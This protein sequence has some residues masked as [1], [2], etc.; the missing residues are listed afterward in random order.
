MRRVH[1]V[2][3]VNDSSE[4]SSVPPSTPDQ[5]SRDSNQYASLHMQTRPTVAV[6]PFPASSKLTV[7]ISRLQSLEHTLTGRELC[8]LNAAVPT[9]EI[10]QPVKDPVIK[11]SHALTE[12]EVLQKNLMKSRLDVVSVTKLSRSATASRNATSA[13]HN[14]SVITSRLPVYS[15]S[16]QLLKPMSK[17][18][19]NAASLRC[20]LNPVSS[21][22]ASP[23]FIQLREQSEFIEPKALDSIRSH[24]SMQVPSSSVDFGITHSDL[25]TPASFDKFGLKFIPPGCELVLQVYS[26]V[27]SI[28]DEQEQLK[29]SYQRGL[30]VA[31]PKHMLHYCPVPHRYF[32]VYNLKLCDSTSSI[33]KPKTST[34]TEFEQIED[35]IY[36][37][38]V[39]EC[40]AIFK[41]LSKRFTHFIT[42]EQFRSELKAFVMVR[43]LNLFGK[44][45]LVKSLQLWKR[46][47]RSQVFSRHFE[48]LELSLRWHS[49]SITSCV[50]AAHACIFNVHEKL[51][52][53][54]LWNVD[55]NR[56]VPQNDLPDNELQYCDTQVMAFISCCK[57]WFHDMVE[58]IASH[59]KSCSQEYLSARD[60]PQTQF[61]LTSTLSMVR[62]MRHEDLIK[63]LLPFVKVCSYMIESAKM[64][65]CISTLQKFSFN[66]ASNVD[67]GGQTSLFN[68]RFVPDNELH[69]DSQSY[70]M[71]PSN[72]SV[73]QWFRTRH[74]E[75]INCFLE[76]T[77]LTSREDILN[78]FIK[79]TEENRQARRSWLLSSD[80]VS[81]EFRQRMN[82]QCLDNLNSTLSIISKG[83]NSFECMKL[84][85]IETPLE[86]RAFLASLN[87]A[88]IR[89]MLMSLF[90]ESKRTFSDTRLPSFI[91]LIKR[92]LSC[93]NVIHCCFVESSLTSI[94]WCTLNMVI[95]LRELDEFA[96]S[97]ISDFESCVSSCFDSALFSSEEHLAQL[98]KELSSRDI[99]PA[100]FSVITSSLASASDRLSKI[101]ESLDRLQIIFS[102]VR[103]SGMNTPFDLA[104]IL[105]HQKIQVEEIHI[106]I[107]TCGE[108][109]GNNLKSA[110]KLLNDEQ[111]YIISAV[112][113][114]R[115]SLASSNACKSVPTGIRS[116]FENLMASLDFCHGI[117]AALVVRGN[118]L[119]S[120]RNAI[121]SDSKV[122][123]RPDLQI[124]RLISD[125]KLAWFGAVEAHD[126]WIKNS[127]VPIAAISTDLFNEE[128]EKLQ[129][130]KSRF[131]ES[132]EILSLP[133]YDSFVKTLQ[134]IHSIVSL[135]RKFQS[136][137]LNDS[138]WSLIS[139]LVA[140]AYLLIWAGDSS[141]TEG[142][143]RMSS[144]TDSMDIQ[145]GVALT[146][147]ECIT[148]NLCSGSV[149]QRISDI[150]TES[151][152]QH[153]LE[154][155]F[156]E[157][158]LMWRQMSFQFEVRENKT[159]FCLL[160]S[161]FGSL[162]ESQTSLHLML[163]SK[164]SNLFMDECHSLSLNLSRVRALLDIWSNI[165]ELW[166]ELEQLYCSS[167]FSSY[168]TRGVSIFERE[169]RR[170]MSCVEVVANRPSVFYACGLC[171]LSG[172]A[173]EDTDI[174]DIKKEYANSLRDGFIAARNE[175]VLYLDSKR[176]SWP[177]LFA[178]S[179]ETLMLAVSQPVPSRNSFWPQL[180][181]S[182]FSSVE[183]VCT[184]KLDDSSGCGSSSVI[185]TDRSK[186]SLN[187]ALQFSEKLECW[188]HI[189]QKAISHRMHE[190][191]K[192]VLLDFGFK[193]SSESA[194]NHVSLPPAKGRS[195]IIAICD[196]AIW[197]RRISQAL[198]DCMP[199]ASG[200][201]EKTYD[202]TRAVEMMILNGQQRTVIKNLEALFSCA[203]AEIESCSV[204]VL[205]PNAMN[206]H[207]MLQVQRMV[208]CTWVRDLIKDIISSSGPAIVDSRCWAWASVVRYHLEKESELLTVHICDQV[209][210]FGYEMITQAAGFSTFPIVCMTDRMRLVCSLAVSASACVPSTL[211][212][213][214]ASGRATTIH[215]VASLYGRFV[216]TLPCCSS[217]ETTAIDRFADLSFHSSQISTVCFIKDIDSLEPHILSHLSAS[218][219]RINDLICGSARSRISATSH[220]FWFLF[221]TRTS[222]NIVNGNI[223]PVASNFCRT[224]RIITI[225]RISLTTCLLK[226]FGFCH[227]EVISQ[228]LHVFYDN[229]SASIHCPQVAAYTSS[230]AVVSYVLHSIITSWNDFR[231][232]RDATQRSAPNQPSDFDSTEKEIRCVGQSLFKVFQPILSSLDDHVDVSSVISACFGVQLTAQS[233][234]T[235]TSSAFP[236]N[237][238]Q[239]RVLFH[240]LG[241]E[242]DQH[243]QTAIIIWNSL[244]NSV[245]PSPFL[246]FVGSDGSGRNVCLA[247]FE[248]ISFHFSQMRFNR[249]SVCSPHGP[250][251]L[252]RL[253]EQ[254]DRSPAISSFN[255]SQTEPTDLE[256]NL[257]KS[258]EPLPTDVSTWFIVYLQSCVLV[259]SFGNGRNSNISERIRIHSKYVTIESGVTIIQQHT[260]NSYIY[261]IVSGSFS[262]IC[263][264]KETCIGA[265]H[266][267]GDFTAINGLKSICSV[268]STIKSSLIMVP[269][270]V[271]WSS[272][273]A[274]DGNKV[275]YSFGIFMFSF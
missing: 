253:L 209:T 53:F 28:L 163:S 55:L 67:Q 63:K 180:F 236:S 260:R 149:F 169:C 40:G 104:P 109:H 115:E 51:E 136:N 60:E 87:L 16:P 36:R 221:C 162:D 91:L 179:T 75:L 196:W 97:R 122:F 118:E 64:Q 59:V 22:P 2:Q 164:F 207:I 83:M 14:L 74:S 167:E 3:P 39:T 68:V 224:S 129:Q 26:T 125:L 21:W 100:H 11:Q 171:D 214:V 188:L 96:S 176:I 274:V 193:D 262:L 119:E 222:D 213:P 148:W 252:Q 259:Q 255:C 231:F 116:D 275:R 160:D 227:A 5:S 217:L 4:L 23:T 81:Q 216:A 105:K 186:L 185:L 140:G 52:S 25:S 208:S 156:Q 257:C 132:R 99:N 131:E 241:V 195:Q 138:H 154:S 139:R 20:N 228:K 251:L 57:T 137:T 120:H 258:C 145:R 88:A 244:I 37:V 58:D 152:A 184:D 127:L 272:S 175:A 10:S 44:F 33:S 264:D 50:Q 233:L 266:V 256:V 215:L 6:S 95:F 34:W 194:F 1:F 46:Q 79:R 77:I 211:V 234:S 157:Q 242:C 30:D 72:H 240:S 31:F 247:L 43:A 9:H 153:Q 210:D 173:L 42:L 62:A 123:S 110:L 219:L 237:Y 56:P 111:Q 49:P 66:F 98:R 85:M 7:S 261:F 159:A 112:A 106:D 71:Y 203:I 13:V 65:F 144:E 170:W 199:P 17:P 41:T 192:S 89:D 121:I 73:C 45:R 70:V 130:S 15:L 84:E 113:E 124:A 172:E 243:L 225:D 158:I 229:L 29:H 267:L 126:F 103:S 226:G 141:A 202:H 223:M 108:W 245:S 35:S 80:C 8:S 146:L 102:A 198:S 168:C 191:I 147:S 187:I 101:E 273:S 19:L 270:H 47:A 90:N 178:V 32:S 174:F 93:R 92:I 165:Q 69:I 265:G 190:S 238:D 82:E 230:T 239:Y 271:F 246:I 218:L 200:F 212:G 201:G 38:T 182:V 263:N 61:K 248:L 220:S 24:I 78:V 117:C 161:I 133:V 128:I 249:F 151:E 268:V 204:I 177:R 235:A 107:E 48:A 189:L 86:C 94:G 76:P 205:Q 181:L 27:C 155:S 54:E 232:E 150:V 143:G 206:H 183:M 166:F 142:L 250:K 134:K 135:A 114:L 18:P 269:S 197:C 254:V 12:D